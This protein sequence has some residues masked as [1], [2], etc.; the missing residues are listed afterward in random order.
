MLDVWIG[1]VNLTLLAAAAGV[2]LLLPGQLFLCFRSRSPAL[3]LA[4]AVLLVLAI[5]FFFLLFLLK[6]GWDRLLWLFFCFYAVFL[7]LVC[8]LGWLI[9]GAARLL[10]HR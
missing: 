6:T 3:Q 4:P 2:V 10:R 1:D 5:V 9:W 7:L 8:G